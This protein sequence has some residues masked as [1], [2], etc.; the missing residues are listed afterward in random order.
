MPGRI[1]LRSIL[2]V[3]ICMSTLSSTLSQ[4]NRD[5]GVEPIRL[6]TSLVV[7]DAQVLNRRTGA[8]VGGLKRE[9]FL[10]HENG[11]RQ[12]ITHF[13]QDKLPL[14]IILLLDL[15]GSVRPYVEQI[16][17]GALQAL[18]RLKPEDEVALLA[19]AT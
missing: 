19:F 3:G 2:I 11:V 5:N 6:G 7:L 12:E 18:S 8:V 9:D 10:I 15:S 1:L 13:S 14:S 4:N 17:D 16:R